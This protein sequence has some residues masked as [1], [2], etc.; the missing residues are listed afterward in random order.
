M[1]P[2]FETHEMSFEHLE[3][4]FDF[5]CYKTLLYS[6]NPQ[7]FRESGIEFCRTVNLPF[8]RTVYIFVKFAFCL[9]YRLSP[10]NGW[11]Q[12]LDHLLIS[13]TLQT[14]QLT[15]YVKDKEKLLWNRSMQ[16]TNKDRRKLHQ[17]YFLLLK[18]SLN[19]K[20]EFNRGKTVSLLIYQVQNQFIYFV[21]QFELG[22]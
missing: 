6:H 3:I 22:M 21:F 4:K 8:C 2:R 18:F 17:N 15:D 5:E 7:S 14:S 1:F 10:R 12:C 9:F 19:L 16:C 20:E 11:I 13:T